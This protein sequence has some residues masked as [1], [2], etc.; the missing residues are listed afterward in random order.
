[1]TNLDAVHSWPSPNVTSLPVA[2]T[3]IF[4]TGVFEPCDPASFR[5]SSQHEIAWDVS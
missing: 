1:M 3:K 5:E 2:M 4:T